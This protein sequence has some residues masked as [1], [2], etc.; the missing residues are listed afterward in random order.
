M[1]TAETPIYLA[2]SGY[3]TRMRG[4]MDAMGYAHVPKH[5]LPTGEQ[6]N[7]TLLGRN[8]R[9]AKASGERV[10]LLVNEQNR[11]AIMAHPDIDTD[12]VTTLTDQ[13]AS[14]PLGPFRFVEHARQQ[15]YAYSASCAGDVYIEGFDWTAF[16]RHHRQSKHAMT[17]MVGRVA[18]GET[19][20]VFDI[21]DGSVR[22]FRRLERF[23]EDVYRNIGVYA[24]DMHSPAVDIMRS[25]LS[26]GDSP[27]LARQDEIAAD[28]IG[29][30]FV[31]AY[32][33]E[34]T[35]FNINRPT[36]YEALL[37]HTETLAA[38]I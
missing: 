22:A 13:A 20:A 5:L 25:Y 35:F 17:F 6:I 16:L 14:A 8:L 23:E 2:A 19:S 18:A 26:A 37:S 3:G 15:G 4:A 34:G 36:D 11:P 24:V 21:D 27:G 1:N 38:A 12:S 33:H 28:L 31:G 9:I 7:Q 10:L 30:G 32:L 29:E